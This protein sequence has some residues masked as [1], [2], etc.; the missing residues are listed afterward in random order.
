M[1]IDIDFKPMTKKEIE[2]IE[3]QA[4]RNKKLDEDL[5]KELKKQK[6]A[7]IKRGGK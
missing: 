4:K 6:Q 5:T 2:K 1:T 3:K 7:Y